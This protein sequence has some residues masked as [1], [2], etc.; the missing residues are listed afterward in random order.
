MDIT[1]CMPW[2]PSEYMRDIKNI[3][4]S[5][6]TTDL[7]KNKI[8]N[9]NNIYD[10]CMILNKV[11]TYSQGSYSN[12]GV[13]IRYLYRNSKSEFIQF[14]Y[15]SNSL[16]LSLL[17][18]GAFITKALKIQNIIFIRW[19]NIKCQFT[20][21]PFSDNI[22]CTNTIARTS[23]KSRKSRKSNNTKRSK[24]NNTNMNTVNSQDNNINRWGTQNK[25]LSDII[26]ASLSTSAAASTPPPPPPPTPPIPP[27]P[28][29]P[30]IPHHYINHTASHIPIGR[31]SY[32]NADNNLKH[33]K[34]N[35]FLKPNNS[36]ECNNVNE[37]KSKIDFS[38]I[39]PPDVDWNDIESD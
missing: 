8:I 13:F 17:T 4:N 31:R 32:L 30:P 22:N 28:H 23:N 2:T 16:Y 20:V 14:A 5:L 21:I 6:K 12:L 25:N 3:Y 39:I 19:D 36:G 18:D 24:N 29:T 35:K 7:V 37:I 10:F 26:S 27:T 15:Q 33:S 9:K 34:A 1:T 38:G 11:V